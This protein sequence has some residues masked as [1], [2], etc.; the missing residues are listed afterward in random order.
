MA[1]CRYNTSPRNAANA[2][3]RMRLLVKILQNDGNRFVPGLI[4]LSWGDETID[5]L[6]ERVCLLLN[7]SFQSDY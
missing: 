6:A 2:R 4:V 5:T 7:C 1:D 3:D